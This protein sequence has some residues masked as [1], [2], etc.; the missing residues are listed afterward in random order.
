MTIADS[1]DES[2]ANTQ[3][4]LET[5]GHLTRLK[6]HVDVPKSTRTFMRDTYTAQLEQQVQAIR[7]QSEDD[8][9]MIASLEV[10]QRKMQ[11][12]VAQFMAR[13]L[14]VR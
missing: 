14:N 12:L 1:N 5:S 4:T 8:C 7:Q 13:Q 6:V 9:Q 3:A 10:S 11:Q 2:T